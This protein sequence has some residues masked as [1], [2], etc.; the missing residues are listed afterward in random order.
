MIIEPLDSRRT[1]QSSEREAGIA[2]ACAGAL[3]VVDM[4]ED[5]WQDGPL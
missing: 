5:S 2:R 3:G 4:R 1:V